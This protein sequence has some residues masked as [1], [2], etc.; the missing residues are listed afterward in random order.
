MCVYYT[1]STQLTS[2]QILRMLVA[3]GWF[4]KHRASNVSLWY[5][6]Q[7]AVAL[8]VVEQTSALGYPVLTLY[9]LN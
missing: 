8:R 3:D 5:L 1:Q 4:E 6:N 7:I 9:Q 2:T